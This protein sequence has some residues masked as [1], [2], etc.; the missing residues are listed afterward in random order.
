MGADSSNENEID[1]RMEDENLVAEIEPSGFASGTVRGRAR[2]LTS[3]RRSAFTNSIV[4]KQG[5]TLWK[6][7][8]VKRARSVSLATRGSARAR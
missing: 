1:S 8:S 7:P 2:F 3:S 6:A 5:S 4:T